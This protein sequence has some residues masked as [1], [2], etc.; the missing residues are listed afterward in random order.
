MLSGGDCD[1][2]FPLARVF[3]IEA[4]ANCG[5]ASFGQSS[6]ELLEQA[7]DKADHFEL[8]F[9]GKIDYGFEGQR[10]R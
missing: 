6:E 9:F 5:S 3:S 10:W 4:Q 1:R 8:T 2:P 7:L